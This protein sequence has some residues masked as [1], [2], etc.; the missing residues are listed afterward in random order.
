[1]M[2]EQTSHDPKLGLYRL[3]FETAG[4]P[5]LILDATGEVVLA[6]Q[7]ARSQMSALVALFHDREQSGQHAAELAFFRTDLEARSRARVEIDFQ[8]RTIAIDGRAH[9]AQYIVV[10]R[11]VS[12]RRRLELRLEA[13]TARD[14]FRRLM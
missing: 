12:E 5:T 14:G 13:I 7:A 1:M 6:N 10:F 3:V 4:D 2:S 8:G 9:G 11:D